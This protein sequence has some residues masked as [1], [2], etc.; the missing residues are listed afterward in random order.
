VSSARPSASRR[1]IIP[2]VA[3]SVALLV[4]AVASEWPHGDGPLLP[5]RV[6]RTYRITYD[7]GGGSTDELTVRRPF[8]A[9]LV[10]RHD[11]VVVADRASTLVKLA[12]KTEGTGWLGFATAPVLGTGDLRFDRVLR[13]AIAD[14]R[15]QV[16]ERRTVAGRRCQV[17][18][19]GTS[20]QAGVLRPFVSSSPTFADICVDADGLLL[21]EDWTL[22]NG[23]VHH[24]TATEVESGVDVDDATF[25]PPGVRVI[26]PDEGGS[27]ARRLDPASGPPGEY[28]ALPHAPAGYRYR[29][30]FALASTAST[31]D[32][33]AGA[34]PRT[35]SVVD[36]W[37]RGADFVVLEQG[38][39]VQALPDPDDLDLRAVELR[40]SQSGG[41][42]VRL[43]G[44]LTRRQLQSIAND[45]VTKRGT[46][47][48]FLDG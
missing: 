17:L 27:I 7:V 8:D 31:N 25:E 28:V 10:T 42:F 35:T 21:A 29:G 38:A 26:G 12:S 9:R 34:S 15:V 18:R 24:R 41:Q 23:T 48:R 30:R 45:L 16:R 39:S 40:V 37:S 6:P 11:G 14:N 33:R 19:V 4:L 2:T 46:G 3:L 5:S 32:P 13:D 36:V 1:W 44:S 20:V 47:L 43:Y 22:D